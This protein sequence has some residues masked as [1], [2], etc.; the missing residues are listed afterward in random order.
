MNY[1]ILIMLFFI[2]EYSMAGNTMIPL[3]NFFKNPEM[4]S[5]SLSPD[6]KHISYMKPWEDGNRMMNIYVKS[7]DSNDELRITDASERSIYGFFWLSNNRIAYIQE[8][9]NQIYIVK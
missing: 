6:G 4:S 9:L 2:G 3:K 8:L 7:M 1:V 5:F